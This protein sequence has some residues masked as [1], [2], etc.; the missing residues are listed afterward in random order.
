MESPKLTKI[1]A[2]IS[3]MKC[4]VEF[5][6]S[7]YAAGMNVVRINSAHVEPS[8]ALRVIQN[9]RATSDKLG[10]LI[11]TKGPEMRNIKPLAPVEIIPGKTYRFEG[12]PTKNSTNDIIYVTHKDFGKDVIVGSKV[13]IDDGCFEF[14]TIEQNAKENYVIC[15]ALNGGVLNGRKS[16]NVPGVKV[17]LPTLNEKDLR[18]IAFAIEQDVEFIAHSFVRDKEDVLVIQKF[19]MKRKVILKLSL[20]LKINKVLPIST[21]FLTMCM[22]S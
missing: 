11:D 8:D 7:L 14:E 19:W 10:I 9:A 12:D 20:K 18:F 3:D 16:I 13:L 2:T 5:L 15:R 1:V 4:E 6:K 21:K 22:V 17:T